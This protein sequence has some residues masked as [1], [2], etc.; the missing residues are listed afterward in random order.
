MSLFMKIYVNYGNDRFSV[1]IDNKA[2]IDELKE[3]IS[4]Q[5]HLTSK[6]FKIFAN[7]KL[8]TKDILINDANISDGST[9]DIVV[10]NSEIVKHKK[11]EIFDEVED[12]QQQINPMWKYLSQMLDVNLRDTTTKSEI[13]NEDIY[14]F[15]GFFPSSSQVHLMHQQ[16]VRVGLSMIRRG[17][18]L[19]G[20]IENFKKRAIKPGMTLSDLFNRENKPDLSIKYQEQI[21]TMNN[22]GFHDDRINLQALTATNGDIDLAIE[23]IFSNLHSFE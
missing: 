9:I 13:S 12:N 19:C 16:P 8:I 18:E 23:W 11:T 14:D 5:I 6:Q 7:S 17:F 21:R 22:F 10:V 2:T 20:G 15:F 4:K 1:D 3:K